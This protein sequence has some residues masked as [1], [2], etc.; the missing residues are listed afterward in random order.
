MRDHPATLSWPPP[1][2]T[3][4]IPELSIVIPV[5]EERENIAPLLEEIAAALGE[6]HHEVIVVDDGSRD[7]TFDAI[8][9]LCA[10]DSRRRG[11][12][13]RTNG[14]KSAA[15]GAG[16]RAA[17]A[18]LVATMDGDLQDDPRD[19]LALESALKDD[20][21]MVIGWKKT[22]KSSKG[23]FV[24]SRLLNA[25]LRWAT[26]ARFHD[27]N[28]PLR[29]MRR[30]VAH[31]LDLRADLHRYI[32]LLAKSNGRR[33]IEH[34][35]SNRPRLHGESKY[36]SGKYWSSATAFL[37]MHLFLKYGERPM[38]LFGGLGLLCFLGGSVVILYVVLMFIFAGSNIDDDI[39]TLVLGVLMTLVGTQF[40][41][42]GLL[43]EIL[44]R[45]MKLV[46]DRA[47]AEVVEIVGGGDA[48]E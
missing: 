47:T 6:R 8:R 44:V 21:D 26:G 5:F 36:T 27:M 37:G 1:T 24:L 45:K 9:D 10:E 48:A 13:L 16:F 22:G 39:P 3:E 32:P 19:I 18:P 11:L 38:A 7:G 23:T 17:R 43:G 30:E 29:I 31:E 28:C 35:V 42:L 34:P 25:L 20:V 2:M 33:I 12:R 41:G 40:L 15:Y 4:S 46:E 14:G